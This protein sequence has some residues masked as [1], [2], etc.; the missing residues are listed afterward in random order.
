MPNEIKT[1]RGSLESF[2]TLLDQYLEL[3]PDQPEIG[4]MKLEALPFTR[5][6][7]NSF[8]DWGRKLESSISYQ[9]MYLYDN[10]SGLSV[11]SL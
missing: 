6:L 1:Y 2:K 4:Y 3:L 8:I 5:K 7:S 9:T 10:S 11:I